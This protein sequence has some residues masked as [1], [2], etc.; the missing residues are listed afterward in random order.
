M[1]HSI[2]HITD[3][4]WMAPPSVVQLPFKRIVGS[5]NLYLMGRQS[6]FSSKVQRCLME[7]LVTLA[8]D[9]LVFSGDLT[10]QALQ[11]EFEMARDAL[12]PVMSAIPTF[13]IAGNH[14][15]Y[16]QGAKRTRRIEQYFGEQMFWDGSLQIWDSPQHFVVGLHASRPH[17][18]LS[19]GRVPK[20][21]LN[22]LR[23]LLRE[24]PAPGRPFVLVLHYPILDRHGALYD[25]A[26]HGLLNAQE[27]IDVLAEGVR[28]PT[29]ILH[30]HEH[31]GYTVTLK[32]GE[33]SSPIFDCGSSGYA[34]LP[35]KKR[36]AAM[37]V[38]HFDGAELQG[39][40]RYLFDGDE[41]R[42]ENGGAYATGR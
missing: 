3:V 1:T 31:H 30:G 13:I 29:L 26:K 39:L 28:P 5:A 37:N 41:F 2:A 32:L 36:A 15:V 33:R 8:P 27:L 6:H 4:H 34:Y 23:A 18:V 22:A 16:T 40:D 21:Q 14:D 11:S 19:S 24:D 9:A 20:E 38:Y 7:H 42:L 35:K 10:A 17:L 25:G 12:E